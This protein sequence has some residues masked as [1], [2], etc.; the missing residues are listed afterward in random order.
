MPTYC[1][2]PSFPQIKSKDDALKYSTTA[3]FQILRSRPVNRSFCCSC[4]TVQFK[5]PMQHSILCFRWKGLKIKGTAFFILPIRFNSLSSNVKFE[6]LAV[7]CAAPKLAVQSSI[8][9]GA[10]ALSVC[11][12]TESPNWYVTT[13][14][15]QGISF[16]A[17]AWSIFLTVNFKCAG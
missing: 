6:Y 17:Y 7:Y 4:S 9:L 10:Q 13:H 12:N 14:W 5:C 15:L 1:K 3:F 11:L 16:A 2:C 8:I